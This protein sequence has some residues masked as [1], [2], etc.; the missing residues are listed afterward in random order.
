MRVLTGTYA[1][2]ISLDGSTDDPFTV[3]ST[4]SIA[5]SYGGTALYLGRVFVNFGMYWH[6]TN[7]GRIAAEGT[8][9]VGVGFEDGGRLVNGASTDTAAYISGGYRAIS[10]PDGVGAVLNYGTIATTSAHSVGV[11]LASGGQVENFGLI[12][13]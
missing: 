13:N 5:S 2:G 1:N 7:Y 6:V 8:R 9:S 4:G 12:R 10:L 3:A 11:Y